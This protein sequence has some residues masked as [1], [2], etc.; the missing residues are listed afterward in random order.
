M[1]YSKLIKPIKKKNYAVPITNQENTKSEVVRTAESN[2]GVL[3]L[4]TRTSIQVKITMPSLKKGSA[5]PFEEIAPVRFFEGYSIQVAKISTKIGRYYV[6]LPE[7]VRNSILSLYGGNEKTDLEQLKDMGIEQDGEYLKLIECIAAETILD[8]SMFD[9]DLRLSELLR[10]EKSRI[11][12]EKMVVRIETHKYEA[13]DTN[14]RNY[15]AD[16]NIMLLRPFYV[17]GTG[18]PY[19]TCATET[20]NASAQIRFRDTSKLHEWFTLN[21]DKDN[22]R[23]TNIPFMGD[24]I[25]YHDDTLKS[26]GI[27]LLIIQYPKELPLRNPVIRIEGVVLMKKAEKDDNSSGV[28]RYDPELDEYKA[29]IILQQNEVIEEI[30]ET[31]PVLKNAEDH[32]LNFVNAELKIAKQPIEISGTLRWQSITH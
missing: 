19:I 8:Y 20:R 31:K 16:T 26:A 28:N 29:L 7:D 18:L 21:I 17:E 11:I 13:N 1:G 14:I 27:D 15:Q 25:R 30:I 23:D 3:I 9:Y 10:T 4:T 6:I 5:A 24:A 32:C 22:Y 2:N 12:N